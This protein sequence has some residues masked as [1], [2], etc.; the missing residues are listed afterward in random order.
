MKASKCYVFRIVYRKGVSNHHLV[1][2]ETEM[3]A[4]EK[5]NS[6]AEKREGSGVYGWE[7]AGLGKL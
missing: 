6:I 7:A 4:E 3:Q 2:A 5:E 1:W